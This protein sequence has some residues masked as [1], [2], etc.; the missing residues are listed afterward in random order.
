MEAKLKLVK[1]EL[2]DAE[3]VAL[4]KIVSDDPHWTW[5]YL[6]EDLQLV[7]RILRYALEQRLAKVIEVDAGL[8]EPPQGLGEWVKANLSLLKPLLHEALGERSY[9]NI[10]RIGE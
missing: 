6:A 3:I 2:S 1:R 9:K 10:R 5:N 4:D 8:A 7:D